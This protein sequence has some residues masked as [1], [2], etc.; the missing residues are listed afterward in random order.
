M[1]GAD[2]LTIDRRD[3][4]RYTGA[5]AGTSGLL[6][7]AGCLGGGDD[8]D[9]DNGEPGENGEDDREIDEDAEIEHL[10]IT[11]GTEPD[12]LDPVGHNDTPTW[13]AIS[14]AY[15]PILNRNRDGDPEPH[16]AEEFERIDD[17]TIELTIR[18]GV[19]FHSGNEMT[20]DDVAFSINRTNDPEVSDQAAVI[21]DIDEAVAD[22][23]DTVVVNLNSA[24][25]PFFRNISAFGRVMEREWT[26]ARDESE[27]ATEMNGT[28]P[29][30]LSDY[31]EASHV[32]Y[33]QFDDYWGDEPSVVE[34]EFNWTSG[35]GE[36]VAALEGGDTDLIT[37]VNPRDVGDVRDHEDLRPET[38]PSIRN[39]FLVMPNDSEPFDSVEFRQAMNYAVDVDAIVDSLLNDFGVATSQPTLEGH[40]GH[41][42]SVD[43]YP[44]DLEQAEEL[45]EESGYAG[46][47][48]DIHTTTG[49]YLRDTDVAATAAEQIDELS[50]VT[51]SVTERE[52]QELFDETATGD[53][54]DS[55]DIFLIGW[56]NPTFDANYAMDSWFI[57]G[58]PFWHFEDEEIEGLLI[59]AA[60]E[61]DQETREGLLQDAN[62][63]A[64][65][66]ASWVFLHQ[67]IGI[68]GINDELAW[69][70]REDEDVRVPEFNL[71]Q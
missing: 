63:L 25:A 53:M 23:D 29:Y 14:P 45:V 28:G 65:E 31:D 7:L 15:E 6:A 16:L 64:H 70:A 59:E 56:G 9:D 46:V 37:N 52:T 11:Q 48:I 49:R 36:R 39:I 71:Y 41:D 19:M 66:R 1:Q 50:N 69:E 43:P 3:L 22:G 20:A 57:E 27:I 8:D 34:A 2:K 21:G 51:A 42:P 4:M 55:P 18:Q 58:S 54:A 44:H 40:F 62:R 61:T 33:E 24:E 67:Q 47:E 60:G 38:E 30:V 32:R 26:E 12:T 35:E 10:T 5:A 17:T 68:Y 13:N